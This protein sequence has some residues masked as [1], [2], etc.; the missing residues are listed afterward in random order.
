MKKPL[1]IASSMQP[2]AVSN[3]LSPPTSPQISPKNSQMDP[4]TNSLIESS[5]PPK[6]M[7]LTFSLESIGDVGSPKA[8]NPVRASINSLKDIKSTK[9]I[10]DNENN[11]MDDAGN[12][13]L[14]EGGQQIKLS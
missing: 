7:S 2:Q 11:L 10:L 5:H 6:S 8:K 1:S 3:L 9:Y 12:Y 13:I 14:D 4:Q